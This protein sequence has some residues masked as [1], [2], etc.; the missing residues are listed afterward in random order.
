MKNHIQSPLLP[1]EV[2]AR[3]ERRAIRASV[4]FAGCTGLAAF[5]GL[6]IRFWGLSWAESLLMISLSSLSMAVGIACAQHIHIREG[7]SDG[8]R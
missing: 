8:P 3:K 1:D 7:E 2:R 4:L 6:L 5:D